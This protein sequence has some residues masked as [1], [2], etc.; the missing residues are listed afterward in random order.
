MHH[1]HGDATAAT[2]HE[3]AGPQL[4]FDEDQPSRPAGVEPVSGEPWQI[5]GGREGARD[6]GTPGGGRPERALRKG[7]GQRACRLV[8]ARAGAVQPGHARLTGHQL[9][10]VAAGPGMEQGE[11]PGE[12]ASEPPCREEGH[13]HE[14]IDG[15]SFWLGQRLVGHSSRSCGLHRAFPMSTRLPSTAT[16]SLRRRAI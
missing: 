15:S 5:E 14:L 9:P 1:G 10:H 16:F 4:R 8:F 6:G 11:G 12:Q 7:L 2:G 13:P 3:P